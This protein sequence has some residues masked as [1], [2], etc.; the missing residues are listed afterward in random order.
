MS[1]KDLWQLLDALFQAQRQS[2]MLRLRGQVEGRTAELSLALA[3]NFSPNLN[4]FG[5]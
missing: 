3:W 2:T 4:H 1:L 5:L